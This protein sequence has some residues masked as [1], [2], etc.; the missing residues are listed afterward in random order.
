[1][2]EKYIRN[3]YD[4]IFINPILNILY[5][6]SK[7]TPNKITILSLIFGIFGGIL[8]V[9]RWQWCALLSI[10]ISGYLDSLDGSLAR[11]IK[12]STEIGT[13]LDIVSDRIVEFA[14]MLGLYV[15]HPQGRAIATL[16]M[17]GSS[18][19]CVT[20][21]LT[22][23]IFSRNQSQKSFNYD[24]GFMERPEAFLFFILMLWLPNYFLWF[25]WIYVFFVLL[26]AV[27]RLRNFFMVFG[28]NHV[29]DES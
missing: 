14:I 26:T 8:I 27:L 11:K 21:F 22:V 4:Q 16:F 23:G 2:I 7:W 9:L 17:L 28:G 15:V 1:M 13:M 18:Y 25:A 6:N 10:L 20:S 5:K 24:V 19:I 3:T 29:R 12:K